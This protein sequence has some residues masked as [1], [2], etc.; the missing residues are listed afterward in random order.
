MDN[1][2]SDNWHEAANPFPLSLPQGI[3][4]LADEFSAN[5]PWHCG[6]DF[7]YLIWPLSR[8]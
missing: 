6:C 3:H 7:V 1:S 4:D 8:V 5:G 2:S